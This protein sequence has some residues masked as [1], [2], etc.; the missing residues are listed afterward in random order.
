MVAG[1]VS[2]P[3]VTGQRPRIHEDLAAVALWDGAGQEAHWL[4]VP[5]SMQE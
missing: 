2:S 3:L 1:D 4:V 5:A